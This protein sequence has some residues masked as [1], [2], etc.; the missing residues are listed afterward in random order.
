[1]SIN[2]PCRE[3]DIYTCQF[4]SRGL[5]FGDEGLPLPYKVLAKV[6]DDDYKV[7]NRIRLTD[8]K[9]KRQYYHETAKDPVNNTYFI[10]VA[11]KRMLTVPDE[12][13]GTKTEIEHPYLYVFVIA[14]L[15]QPLIMIEK[16]RVCPQASG[17]VARVLSQSLT[18]MLAK[19]GWTLILRKCETTDTH[20]QCMTA[21]G[22][23]MD[24]P[25]KDINTL[26]ELH[27]H[28]MAGKLLK[29]K[30]R[31]KR[32]N[33]RNCINNKTYA[34]TIIRLLHE[35]IDG[36]TKPKDI[37]RPIRAAL[38]AKAIRKVTLK[39]FE[40]EFG[41]IMN[42]SSTMFD[43]YQNLTLDYFKDDKMYEE[44]LEVFAIYSPKKR[45]VG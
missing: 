19:S 36:K 34:D 4:V 17:E 37:M 42:D 11:N 41:D 14:G 8:K 40:S 7:V 33:F 26:E 32:L 12:H 29:K 18:K 22:Y 20:A 10:R 15:E 43:N 38:V 39:E 5:F 9:T 21:M 2:A 35:Y 30:R 25:V 3:F 44:M 45:V 27:G 23:M 1:M 6:M 31:P 28:E 24:D 13:C 16:C